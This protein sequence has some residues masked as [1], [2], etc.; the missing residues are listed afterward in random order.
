[1]TPYY[2]LFALFAG[3]ALLLQAYLI[4]PNT[5]DLLGLLKYSLTAY[6]LL[7]ACYFL[8]LLYFTNGMKYF[9]VRKPVIYKFFSHIIK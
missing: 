1:M 6:P 2:A 5:K 4:S 7:V 9:I 8:A 3:I